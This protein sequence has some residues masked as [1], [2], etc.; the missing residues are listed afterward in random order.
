MEDQLRLTGASL[1][2]C[3]RRDKVLRLVRCGLVWAV[4]MPSCCTDPNRDK[5][6][7]TYGDKQIQRQTETEPEET[8]TNKHETDSCRV[9]APNI[10]T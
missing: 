3:G 2:P 5:P 7:R 9:S 4:G 10:N 8:N 6:D 1:L